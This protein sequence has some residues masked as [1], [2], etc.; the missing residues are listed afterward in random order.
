MPMPEENNQN[1][2]S[3]STETADGQPGSPDNQAAA[4]APA[5]TPAPETKI[6]LEDD[7]AQLDKLNLLRAVL[8][9]LQGGRHPNAEIDALLKRR[10]DLR[11]ED[12]QGPYA[13]R[14]ICTVMMIFLICIIFWGVIWLFSTAFQLN[15][16]VRL[17]SAGIA[18]LLAAA[19]G[20]AIFHPASIPDEKQ[21]KEAI[22][23]RLAEL[24]NE[25]NDAAPP[26]APESSETRSNGKSNG[27]LKTKTE[28]TAVSDTPDQ[29]L[30]TTE[31]EKIQA[32]S[33]QE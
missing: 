23:R 11:A 8:L 6:S 14:L 30:N 2:E 31:E 3:V 5:E 18:T 13:V 10:L 21:V 25:G 27:S 33:K 28:K 7:L 16:F 15:Y 22:S 24:K 32:E 12:F 9:R 20:I 26:P 19:A 1:P 17:M 4:A 29:S